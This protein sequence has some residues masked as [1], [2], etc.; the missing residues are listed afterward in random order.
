MK[1]IEILYNFMIMDANMN[2]FMR[3]PDKV[4]ASQAHRMDAV[5]GDSSWRSAAYKTTQDLFGEL[6]HK[7]TNEDIAAAFRSRL[8][9]VARFAYVPAPMPMRNSRGAIVYYLYF[10]SPNETGAK[11]ITE[12]FETYR[13]RGSA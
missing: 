6:E 1:S 3:D 11:I 13:L 10:A 9:E 8:E 12:I 4:T 5:W 2:V 7:A